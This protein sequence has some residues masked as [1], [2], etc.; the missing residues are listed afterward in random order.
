MPPYSP[1]LNPVE[2]VFS[3][4]KYLIKQREANNIEDLMAAI[5]TT[6]TRITSQ[7]CQNYFS[8]MREYVV[9]TLR[10]EPFELIYEL[11]LFVNYS[12]LYYFCMKCIYINIWY[13][14]VILIHSSSLLF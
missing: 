3:K 4:W 14:H 12:V 8:H 7:E 1:Q 11:F 13:S 6:H 2:E 10:R 5:Q 9:T